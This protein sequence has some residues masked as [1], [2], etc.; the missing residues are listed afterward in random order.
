MAGAHSIHPQ[1]LA[2]VYTISSKINYIPSKEKQTYLY[3]KLTNDSW[4][5]GKDDTINNGNG[6]TVCHQIFVT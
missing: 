5:N 4:C 6:N 1:F 3:T 2:K